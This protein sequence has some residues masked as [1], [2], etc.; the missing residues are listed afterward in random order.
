MTAKRDFLLPE[1][2]APGGFVE[3]LFGLPVDLRVGIINAD[4]FD[5]PNHG[6]SRVCVSPPSGPIHT[7][8]ASVHCVIDELWADMVGSGTEQPFGAMLSWLDEP[9]YTN[10]NGAP[11]RPGAVFHIVLIGDSP[12]QSDIL[13]E[14]VMN[15]LDQLVPSRTNDVTFHALAFPGDFESCPGVRIEGGLSEVVVHTGGVERGI[16]DAGE[17]AH[18]YDAV[19]VAIGQ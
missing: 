1:V 19:L 16:C 10:S 3:R 9:R 11:L 2:T 13:V 6:V 12:D 5:R 8:A 7:G 18:F 15:T 17:R 4:E 14:D